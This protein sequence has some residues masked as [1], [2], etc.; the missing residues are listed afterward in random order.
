MGRALP[1]HFTEE[2]NRGLGDCNQ[3]RLYFSFRACAAVPGASPLAHPCWGPEPQKPF[4]WVDPPA[5]GGFSNAE[6]FHL[7]S[8]KWL[9]TPPY[10]HVRGMSD[11]GG[12]GA[13]LPGGPP[14]LWG[15]TSNCPFHWLI[16]GRGPEAVETRPVVV[17]LGRVVHILER[18]C[19]PSGLRGQPSPLSLGHDG[20]RVPGPS[21]G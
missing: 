1:P 13:P 6:A 19:W 18:K 17:G 9:E 10:P 16:R 11:K 14:W 7:A 21:S 4:L 5:P 15:L 12:H 8:E 3:V 2:E 20:D